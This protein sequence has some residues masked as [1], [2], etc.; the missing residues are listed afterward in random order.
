[1]KQYED[2][3]DYSFKELGKT[4]KKTYHKSCRIVKKTYKIIIKNNPPY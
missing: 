3:F 4:V 2:T 1:M